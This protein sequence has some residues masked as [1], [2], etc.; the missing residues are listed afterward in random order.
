MFDEGNV[1]KAIEQ[2]L[3]R[4]N[5]P[6]RKYLQSVQIDV[7]LKDIDMKKGEVKL[8]ESVVLP[9]RPSKERRVFVIPTIEQ[10]EKVKESKPATIMTKDELQKLQGNKKVA[11]KIAARH[12]WFLIAQ[13]SMAL[14]GR[15]LGPALG[16]RGKFPI[17]VPGNAEM[18]ELVDRYKKSTIVKTKDQPHIQ[19]FVGTENQSVNELYGNIEAVMNVIE[20]KIRV[21]FI[22]L[23]YVK[24]DMGKPQVIRK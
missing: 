8:R 18:S 7:V 12:E 19:V 24:T 11:K 21:E 6:E 14:A 17:P 10:L 4:E 3:S 9:N 13:D 23:L 1:K 5:N 15:V 20:S 2:A 22:K 16:P